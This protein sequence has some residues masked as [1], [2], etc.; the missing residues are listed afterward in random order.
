LVDG[1]LFPCT[2]SPAECLRLAFVHP[3]PIMGPI[4]C[5]CLIPLAREHQKT[6]QPTLERPRMTFAYRL[7]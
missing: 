2:G 7:P 3:D 6:L 4:L 1:S 5:R